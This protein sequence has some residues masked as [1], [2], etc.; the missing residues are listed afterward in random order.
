MWHFHAYAY[1]FRALETHMLV[2]SIHA[3]KSTLTCNAMHDAG[4]R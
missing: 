1:R 3:G 4:A 2:V